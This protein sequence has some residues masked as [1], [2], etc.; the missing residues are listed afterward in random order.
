MISLTRESADSVAGFGGLERA[1]GDDSVMVILMAAKISENPAKSTM[2][3]SML[4]VLHFGTFSLD[5]YGL[6]AP[7][8]GNT[9]KKLNLVCY[10]TSKFSWDHL[11][12]KQ[13]TEQTIKK[14]KFQQC[15]TL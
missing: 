2:K 15:L 6:Q 10:G 9:T 14:K 11:F 8:P 4:H 7:L 12:G 1:I 5:W 13:E 3:N